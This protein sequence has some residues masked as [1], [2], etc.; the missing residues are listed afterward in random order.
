MVYY[1]H[2]IYLFQDG[3]TLEGEG[4][5]STHVNLVVLFPP[6]DEQITTGQRDT[7][8]LSIS[9]TRNLVGPDGRHDESAGSGTASQGGTSTALPNL[10]LEMS[11]VHHLNKLHIDLGGEGRV[12]LQ[13]WTVHL[14]VNILLKVVHK[15]DG[16]R[17]AH[18]NGTDLPLL[19]V[20]L[21]CLL[22]HRIVVG[23]RL[24]SGGDGRTV[25]DG[26]AHVHSDCLFGIII[27]NGNDRAGESI[28]VVRGS[29]GSQIPQEGSKATDAVA[30]HLGLTAITV[31]DPH[32]EVISAL[33][34][35]GALNGV[36]LEGED[37]TISAN[38]KVAMA[39]TL[40]LLRRKRRSRLVPIVDEDEIVAQTLV[41]GEFYG[42]SLR[43]R[44]RRRGG[45]GGGGGGRARCHGGRG[46]RRRT[47]GTE[48]PQQ[49]RSGG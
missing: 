10:H 38:A 6:L 30:A 13:G 14:K 34:L 2:C 12:A 39:Q 45:G 42:V 33:H 41:L 43:K 44:E 32:G 46:K 28:D 9:R 20:A 1:I 24:E 22:D 15:D 4:S 31:V 7:D 19:T 18:A 8:L 35:R 40:R 5:R 29:I 48:S 49:G 36:G 17:V 23:I 27:H 21:Q 16:M 26:R 3:L 25:Q 11:W 47:R 37:D